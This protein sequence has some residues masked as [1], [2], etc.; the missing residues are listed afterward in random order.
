[1]AGLIVR[2]A[3]QDE[4]GAVSDILS[5]AS[6][7]VRCNG[8]DQWPER[9]PDQ[10]IA[11]GIARGE[12][13]LALDDGMAVGTLT[14]QWDDPRFW[15]EGNDAG[16]VHRLALVSSHRGRGHGYELLDWAQSQIAAAGRRYLR[17][18]C[19]AENTALRNYYEAAG[20]EHRGDVSGHSSDPCGAG[21]PRWTASLYERAGRMPDGS[22]PLSEGIP[23]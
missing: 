18:D 22:F 14:L 6:R 7:W 5:D 12:V 3:Q 19:G 20:F 21:R 15:D 17:L 2:P 4:G 16:Y 8:I 11:G 13:Y 9:F 1:M 23:R 10:L